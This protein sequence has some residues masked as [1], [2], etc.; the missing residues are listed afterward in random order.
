MSFKDKYGQNNTLAEEGNWV[1]LA[2]DVWIKIRRSSS[3]HA[4]KILTSLMKPYEA[5]RARGKELTPSQQEEVNLRF[6]QEALL[7]DWDIP[8]LGTY[9]EADV[10]QILREAPDFQ[11]DI[12]TQ[13]GILDNFKIQ[14]DVERAKNS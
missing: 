2:P 3:K 6:I 11:S 14:Q 7:V 1:E 4:Q 13:S 12:V 5:A 9:A 10:A 8:E